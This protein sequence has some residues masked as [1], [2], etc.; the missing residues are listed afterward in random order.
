VRHLVPIGPII[1]EIWQFLDFSRWRSSA[2]L[3]F[4]IQFLTAGRVK[5]AKFC[6]DR[7]NRC[8]VIAF[9]CCYVAWPCDFDLWPLTYWPWTV[10]IHGRSLDQPIHQVW[11][12]YAYPFLSYELWRLPLTTVENTF[13]CHCA[14]AV[15]RDQCVAGQYFP[16]IW[17]PW[18]R[19]V[20]SLCNLLGSTTNEKR[21]IR[22]NSVLPCVESH[23]TLRMRLVTWSVNMGSKTT[24][25]LES[26]TYSLYHFYWATIT[27]KG[28]LQVRFLPLGGFRLKRLQSSFGAKFGVWRGQRRLNAYFRF[29]NPKRH[30][31]RWR[32]VIWAIVRQNRSRGLTFRGAWEKSIYK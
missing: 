20:S 10:V 24:T 18:P 7:S 9:C 21:V 19:F 16:Y 5:T 1:A 22:H 27:I 3:V 13:C 32:R 15:L 17:N 25:Y 28:R 31:L 12:S 8:W 14:C 30:T 6:G 29:Y 2:I 23:A 11:R 26:S 4:K